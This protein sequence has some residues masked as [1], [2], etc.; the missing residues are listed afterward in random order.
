MEEKF[1]TGDIVL[2]IRGRDADKYYVVVSTEGIFAYIAN[3]KL[4]KAEK[5]KKKKIKHLKNTHTT[6]EQ[7]MG[8]Q[9][10]KAGISNPKLRRAI[11]TFKNYMSGARGTI[12]PSGCA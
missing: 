8:V 2:S 12:P 9:F 4:H 7:M 10:D 6:Y 1:I 3:G 11:T 5:P